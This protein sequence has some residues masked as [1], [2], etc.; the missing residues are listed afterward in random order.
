[1][2]SSDIIIDNSL[3]C[4]VKFTSIDY[5]GATK[6]TISGTAATDKDILKLVENLG[7]QKLV[8]QATLGSMSLAGGDQGRKKF[9]VQVIIKG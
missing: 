5:N 8:R 6:A 1:M 3:S 7:K 4:W 2:P 9:K